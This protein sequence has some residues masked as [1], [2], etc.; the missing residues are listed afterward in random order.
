MKQNREI[1]SISVGGKS[2][3]ICNNNTAIVKN[4]M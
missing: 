1:F 2:H 4:V 3:I